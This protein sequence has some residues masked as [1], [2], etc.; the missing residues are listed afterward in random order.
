[1]AIT[2]VNLTDPVSTFVTK[3]NTISGDLGDVAE[4][5]AGDSNT[6]DAINRLAARKSTDSAQVIGLARS[7]I[8]STGYITYDSNTGVIGLDSDGIIQ[9]VIPA[10][11]TAIGTTNQSK[12]AVTYD[13]NTGQIGTDSTGLI[14]IARTGLS[15]QS[16]LSYSPTQGLMGVDFTALSQWS[17]GDYDSNTDFF[18]MVDSDAGARKARVETINVKNSSGTIVAKLLT[19]SIK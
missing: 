8:S 7:A 1:M 9:T 18:I 5:W 17:S 12:T 11:R 2:I 3:T 15:V 4:L 13:S 14:A 19:A 6:V 10:A 16:P